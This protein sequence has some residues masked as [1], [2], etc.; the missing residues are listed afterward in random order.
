MR[1]AKTANT[2]AKDNYQNVTLKETKEIIQKISKENKWSMGQTADY[3][4]ALGK[5]AYD[6]STK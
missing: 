3:L 2:Y 1:T 4:I 5:K 6:M